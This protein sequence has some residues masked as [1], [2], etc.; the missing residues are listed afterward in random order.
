MSDEYRNI[1][2]VESVYVV[3]VVCEGKLELSPILSRDGDA[4]GAGGV[5]GSLHTQGHN[6]VQVTS[7]LQDLLFR[8]HQLWCDA[9]AMIGHT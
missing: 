5:E 4:R 1:K 3:R 7:A 9:E 8:T 6:V 2:D